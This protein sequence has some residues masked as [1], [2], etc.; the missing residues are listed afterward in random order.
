MFADILRARLACIIDLSPAQVSAL[1]AHYQLLLRWNRTLNLT[2]VESLE[3]AVERHYCESVFLASHLPAGPL[4]VADI[5]SGAGF[6]GFPVAVARPDCQV[7]LIESHQRKAVFLRE[8]SRSV[9]NVRVLAGRAESVTETFDHAISRAVSYADLAKP[10]MLLA[11]HADLLS[12][13]DA[14]PDSMPIEWQP[15]IPLPWGKHR[16]LRIG[17]AKLKQQPEYSA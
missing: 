6:P 10:L 13:V 9:P 1:D 7:T 4:R 2:R 12:G 15:A 3:E 14:P 17:R 5:G 16:V 8:A 11:E